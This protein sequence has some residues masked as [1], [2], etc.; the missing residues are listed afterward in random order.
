MNEK[1]V[2]FCSWGA[3]FTS[4]IIISM[5]KIQ[6]MS[7]WQAVKRLLMPIKYVKLDFFWYFLISIYLGV[8][9]IFQ[10]QIISWVV[11]AVELKDWDLLKYMIIVFIVYRATIYV[12]N[13]LARLSHSQ[14]WIKFQFRSKE[15]LLG[16]FIKTDN[17]YIE[18][19]W[20]WRM[21]N[22]ID[23]GLSSQT[24][25]VVETIMDFFVSFI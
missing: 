19:F 15:K 11:S 20:T 9:W 3:I 2:G 4:F 12:I 8:A 5:E 6:K 7:F 24:N 16:K 23:D 1:K 14:L 18:K 17:N 13:I 22:I 25:I 21:N 10:V